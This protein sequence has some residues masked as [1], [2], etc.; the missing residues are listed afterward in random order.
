[1]SLLF[2]TRDTPSSGFLGSPSQPV[3][4]CSG[5]KWWWAELSV[6]AMIRRHHYRENGLTTPSKRHN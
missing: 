3:K 6:I 2:L 1:M 5:K 4:S